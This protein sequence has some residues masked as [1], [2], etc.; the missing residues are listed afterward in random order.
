MNDFDEVMRILEALRIGQ[1]VARTDIA[2]VEVIAREARDQAKATNGRVAS[3]EIWRA[4]LRGIAQGSG[5]TGRLFV[6]ILTSAAAT[7]GIVTAAM[8]I[9]ES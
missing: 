4:E 5:G 7:G 8:K 1:V 6:Y 3:L 2:R 9:L